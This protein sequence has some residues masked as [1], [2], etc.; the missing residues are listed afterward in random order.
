MELVTD[1]LLH[2]VIINTMKKFK[3]D[4][5]KI[6]INYREVMDKFL[7]NNGNMISELDEI[8]YI[9]DII[10]ERREDSKN[11]VKS[12]FEKE[13]SISY[14][15]ILSIGL[16]S[17]AINVE[18][19]PICSKWINDNGLPNPNLI[20]QNLLV[21]ISNSSLAILRLTE[22]G[23]EYAARTMYRSVCELSWLTMVVASDKD[24]MK[25][26]AQDLNRKQ[27]VELWSKHFR[28]KNLIDALS[29]LEN[30][31]ELPEDMVSY[32][33]DYRKSL[34]RTYSQILHNSYAQSTLG[35]YGESLSKKDFLDFNLFGKCTKYSK[36]ILDA[37][38]EN[39]YYLIM[40]ITKIFINIHK[41]KVQVD[42]ALWLQFLTLKEAYIDS[43]LY[44]KMIDEGINIK[45]QS[46]GNKTIKEIALENYEK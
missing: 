5:N 14:L 15:G 28:G 20:I 46:L 43:F 3:D 2:K 31:L 25:L 10:V 17:L 36:Q 23:L 39:I 42:D 6:G 44:L 29:G 40:S 1:E 33:E 27:E 22:D 34:Y 38:N 45:E 35:V 21:Q 32:F 4:L 9:E 26:Y 18:K 24:K 11:D 30:K 16:L 19:G 8:K 37:L 7:I 13:I 12:N 41:Y